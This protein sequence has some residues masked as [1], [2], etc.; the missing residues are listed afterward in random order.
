MSKCLSLLSAVLLTLACQVEAQEDPM[1]PQWMPDT[2]TTQSVPVTSTPAPQPVP[3]LTLQS[4]SIIGEQRSAVINQQRLTVNEKISGAV[5][6]NIEPGEVSY[7]FRG[8]V[9]TL[10]LY[11]HK[12][13]ITPVD[14]V[15]GDERE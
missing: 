2:N 9:Y 1:K 4:I 5:I 3:V 8:T 12:A 11:R 14:D 6:T 13:L 10:S 15:L 7:R